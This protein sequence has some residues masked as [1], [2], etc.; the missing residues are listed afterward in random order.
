MSDEDGNRFFRSGPKRPPPQHGIKV[1][2]AGLTWW[3]QRW[4]EALERMAPSYAL[5]LARGKTYARAGRTHDLTVQAGVVTAKVTGSR[6]QPYDV[7]LR[8]AQLD[9]AAWQAA[10]ENMAKKAQFSAELLAGEMPRA[11]DEAFAVA[12]ASLFPVRSSDLE[13]KC[14]CPD[15][16]NPC[17]HVAA[18]HY[19]LGEALDRDPFLLFELRGR[20]KAQVLRELRAARSGGAEVADFDSSEVPVTA[21]RLESV[22]A[23]D[24]DAP[25]APLPS[26]HLEFEA[27]SA[28][29]TLLKQLGKPPGWIGEEAPGDVL[30]PLVRAAAD[31]ARAIA[32]ADR[33]ATGASEDDSA[34]FTERQPAAPDTVAPTK[35]PKRTNASTRADSTTRA[36]AAPART[37]RSKPGTRSPKR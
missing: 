28:H 32:M 11:I 27:P 35:P 18:T 17:K 13:T 21:L 30:A 7:E 34:M 33:S 1:K 36:P 26:L 25:R 15:W 8:V 23:E 4:I 10:V 29:A 2:S 5:R 9:G 20:S 19:V 12:D 14:S 3:G 37:R 24:Y 16:A 31:R 6:A 22:S